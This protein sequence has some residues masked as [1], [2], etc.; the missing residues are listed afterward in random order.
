MSMSFWKYSST[1]WTL[2]VRILQVRTMQ[3]LILEMAFTLHQKLGKQLHLDDVCED[4]C[5]T[6]FR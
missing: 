4:D 1:I 6:M 5:E 3:M 2:A